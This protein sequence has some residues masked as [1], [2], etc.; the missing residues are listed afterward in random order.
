MNAHPAKQIRARAE[1]NLLH[2]RD[3]EFPWN[4]HAEQLGRNATF[5]PIHFVIIGCAPYLLNTE[6]LQHHLH[7]TLYRFQG[8][9]KCLQ[10]ARGFMLVVSWRMLPA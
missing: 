10:Y 8:T 2:D 7:I 5:V 3:Y 9:R 1:R 6:Y 4:L